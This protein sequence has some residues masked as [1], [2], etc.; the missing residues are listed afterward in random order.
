MTS[1]G[2]HTTVEAKN[3]K[4][5]IFQEDKIVEIIAIEKIDVKDGKVDLT[6]PDTKSGTS[7]QVHVGNINVGRGSVLSIF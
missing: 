7:S 2:T 4:V 3:N 5:S 6:P 1:T